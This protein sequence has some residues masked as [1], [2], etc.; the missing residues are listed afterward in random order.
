MENL[1]TI[2]NFREN[3]NRIEK[4]IEDNLLQYKKIITTQDSGF[5]TFEEYKM[6]LQ[7]NFTFVTEKYGEKTIQNKIEDKQELQRLKELLVLL[8]DIKTNS[9]NYFSNFTDNK[10][11][12]KTE[13]KQNL[14]CW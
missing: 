9:F 4:D 14:S 2:N 6:F 10:N 1:L 8:E 13:N 11:L 7:K 12:Y 5:K 3:L